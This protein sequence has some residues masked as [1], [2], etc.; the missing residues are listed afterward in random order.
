MLPVNNGR[1]PRGYFV[2]HRVKEHIS[3][4]EKNRFTITN[5]ETSYK[6]RSTH[7]SKLI[8]YYVKQFLYNMNAGFFPIDS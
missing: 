5:N 1:V 2:C 3:I 8:V 7:S 6:G 4:S